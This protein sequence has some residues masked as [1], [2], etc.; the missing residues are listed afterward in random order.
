MDGG[1]AAVSSPPVARWPPAA[2]WRPTAL[3]A[4][5]AWPAGRKVTACRGVTGVNRWTAG[6]V[7]GSSAAGPAWGQGKPRLAA[8]V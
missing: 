4:N 1:S 3:T 5:C 8:E 6:Y 2:R 7:T